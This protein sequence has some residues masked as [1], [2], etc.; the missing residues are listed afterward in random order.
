MSIDRCS[1]CGDLVDTDNE[2]E[3]YV[4]IADGR[5]REEWVCLCSRHREER[6]DD[7]PSRPMPA[8]IDAMIAQEIAADPRY[9]CKNCDWD[10][11]GCSP[12]AEHADV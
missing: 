12:C 7:Q 1:R 5:K 2:P 3:A 11:G 4:Q 10:V 6:E 9:G 8:N